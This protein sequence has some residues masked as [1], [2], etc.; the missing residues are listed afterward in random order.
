[1][2]TQVLDENWNVLAE[3]EAKVS[4]HP[5]ARIVRAKYLKHNR[6]IPKPKVLPWAAV[7]G[8]E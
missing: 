5:R 2:K 6:P 3:Y 7:F 4:S 1:M 8:N